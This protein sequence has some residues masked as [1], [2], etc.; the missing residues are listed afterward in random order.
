MQ[1]KPEA[2]DQGRGRAGQGIARKNLIASIAS[3]Y[4]IASATEGRAAG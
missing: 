3:Q 1:R 4:G 2:G